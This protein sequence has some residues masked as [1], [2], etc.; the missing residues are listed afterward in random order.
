MHLLNTLVNILPGI[1]VFGI[2]VFFHE[3]GHFL[4]AKACKVPVD[5]FSVGFGPTILGFRRGG[6]QYSLA[7]IPLGGFVKMAGDEYPED[8]QEPDPNTFLG[9]PWWHRVVIALAGPGANFLLALVVCIAMFVV[10]IQYADSSNVVG[11]VSPTSPQAAVGLM[12]Q[13][14][15]VE[16]DGQ[17][18]TGGYAVRTALFGGE[19]APRLKNPVDV[20]LTVERLGARVPLTIP[21]AQLAAL[22]DSLRFFQPAEIGEVVS[23]MPAYTAGLMVGDRISSVDGQPVLDWSDLTPLISKRALELDPTGSGEG[24]P[25]ALTV[26]RGDRTLEL[27]VKPMI[28]K[29]D[30]AAKPVAR[31]GISARYPTVTIK[32]GLVES[33]SLGTN[34]TLARTGLTFAGIVSLFTRP[35]QLGQSVSGPIAIIEMSGQ[36]AQRGL[37]TVMNLLVVLSLALMA[38]NLLPIPILDGGL[39]VMAVI[40]G[41]RRKRV[42]FKS[43]MIAQR[44]GFVLLGSLI[45]FTLLN[46]PLKIIRRNRAISESQ[47]RSTATEKAAP[48]PSDAPGR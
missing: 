33:L 43:L 28:Q 1:A 25:I 36:A 38:F 41:I 37:F 48:R 29:D 24:R 23:G 17:A 20:P 11:R 32:H 46:D 42:P 18:V 34:E 14:R 40:E 44:V 2:L 26:L 31:I 7:A 6:T 27:S 4:A 22:N 15:I 16:V 45:L 47:G 19:G 30:G 5:Q 10:G 35:K 21:A 13:D 39:V 3:L 8:D 12:E 9:H